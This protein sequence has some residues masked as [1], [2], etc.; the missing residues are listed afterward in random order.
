MANNTITFDPTV[1]TPYGVNLT[2]YTGADFSQTF[3]ILN[4]DRSAYDL[5]SHTLYSRMM[6]STGQAASL[7]VVANFT[8]TITGATDGEFKITLTDTV[9]RQIKGG[10]YEYDILMGVGSSLYSLA[11]GNIQVYAG[12]STN[13]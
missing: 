9:N 6:K 11:R 12:I 7:D 10:R 2:M 8:E 3:K 13:A 5:T 1:G 4:N